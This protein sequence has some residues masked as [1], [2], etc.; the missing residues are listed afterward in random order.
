[1]KRGKKAEYLHKQVVFT[2]EDA[3][4]PQMKVKERELHL[5]TNEGKRERSKGKRVVII[6]TI[7]VVMTVISSGIIQQLYIEHFLY[8]RRCPEYTD[9]DNKFGM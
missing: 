5:S 3:V 2:C 9:L 4:C 6:V 7:L 1:M 8:S